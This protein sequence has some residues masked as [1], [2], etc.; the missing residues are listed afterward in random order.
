M[1]CPRCV[2]EMAVVEESHID[3]NMIDIFKN[4]VITESKMF[5]ERY[6][7]DITKNNEYMVTY[8]KYR[9]K[10][11]CDKDIDNNVTVF[12]IEIIP[13]EFIYIARQDEIIQ[14]NS[15]AITKK[16]K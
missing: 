6:I 13:D 1:R 7:D 9:C 4:N 12:E 2:R 8:K 16:F 10:Y 3:L 11:C 15:K 5:L 14:K